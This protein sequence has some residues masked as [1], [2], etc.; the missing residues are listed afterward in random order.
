[1]FIPYA[2]TEAID[3]AYAE[4]RV[5]QAQ[6]VERGLVLT[7]EGEAHVVARLQRAAKEVR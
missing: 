6:A 7:L 3:R 1:V 5:L 4:C 2:A